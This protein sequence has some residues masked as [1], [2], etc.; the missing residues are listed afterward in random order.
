MMEPVALSRPD[1]SLVLSGK[2]RG[3]GISIGI[4]GHCNQSVKFLGYLI[5]MNAGQGGVEGWKILLQD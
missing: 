2:T 5:V 3:V 1:R 4:L